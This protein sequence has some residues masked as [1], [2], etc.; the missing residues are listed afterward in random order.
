M[1]FVVLVLAL[2]VAAAQ[3]FHPSALNSI[4]SLSKEKRAV[5]VWAILVA[6]SDGWGNYR[7]QSDICQ[8]FQ[9]LRK[10]D[11][12][13]AHIIVMMKDDIAN[14]AGNPY[15]GEI[16]NTYQ[17]IDVYHGVPKDY[18]GKLVNS[19]NFIK[20][21]TGDAPAGGSGKKLQSTSADHVFVFFD[22]HGGVGELCFPSDNLYEADLE[23]ALNTMHDKKLYG[24][25]V[26]HVEACEAGSMFYE[27][28]LPP[29][30]YFHTASPPST[31][32]WGYMCDDP[33]IGTCLS[34]VWAWFTVHYMDDHPEKTIQNLFDSVYKSMSNW[35][36]P[37][38][39]GDMTITKSV[40]K[41]WYG[42]KSSSSDA[43]VALPAGGRAIK[44]YN[45]SFV[46][47]IRMHEMHKSEK[48]LAA[49][50]KEVAI[51]SVVDT[52]ANRLAKAAHLD[53]NNLGDA[54]CQEG[55]NVGTCAKS[56]ARVL[57]GSCGRVSDYIGR[58][59]EL[60][61]PICRKNTN[62]AKFANIITNECQKLHS[63]L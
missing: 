40:I 29:N 63:S 31:S 16:F 44:S 53:L 48:T 19:K 26:F 59:D 9:T 35:S 54:I 55:N 43:P 21:L 30:A 58:V 22:D 27:A 37:C 28:K 34:D 60:L 62:V 14:Y 6:G 1:K 11:V 12:P 56:L 7:H 13:E 10:L 41:E 33:E 50:N 47:M 8:M 36:I 2:L 61:F 49:L 46:S 3:A 51:H 25:L 42:T 15:P 32:S 18:T 4:V 17:H 24:S 57:H 5:N 52:M 38:Q 45:V 23:K 20:L 39:Y